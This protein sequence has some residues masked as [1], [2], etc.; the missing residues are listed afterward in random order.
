MTI[1]LDEPR[2]VHL[3]GIGG[4]GMSGI[5]RMLLQ[6]GHGVTGSD[7]Q[8]G[9]AVEGLRAMGAEIRIGHEADAVEGADLVVTSSAIDDD[10]VELEAAR[11][12]GITVLHRAE[13]LATLMRGD[14]AV[15]VAGTH[16]KTTTTSMIVVALQSAGMDPSFAIGG[17]LNEAGSNAH[18]GT[19]E[20]FVAEAD[21]SDRSFLS[22]R[23]DVAVVT[24]VELDHHEAFTS[25]EDTYEAFRA[26]LGRRSDDGVAVIC[27]DDEG[28]AELVGRAAGRGRVVTYGED[29]SADVRLIVDRDRSTADDAHALQ[30][31]RVR[32]DGRDLITFELSVPGVHNLLNATAALAVC[33]LVDADL[34]AAAEGLGSFTGAQR[35]FQRLGSAAGVE[36]VDDYA[37]HPT[38]LRVTLGAARSVARERVVLVVQP[39]RFSRTE[40]L[41]PELGRAAVGADVVVVTD[42]YGAD[43]DPVPGITGE[44]V[45]DA[46]R[47]AG[48][49]VIWEPHL[50][51]VVE[52]L[53][54]LVE[55]G[56]LVLVTGA[57]D[58]NEVGP[59]LLTALRE[60]RT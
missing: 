47:D 4:A 51:G 22:Y 19:G 6:R 55:D 46:A 29:P 24:N 8:E 12:T 39:H 42:V 27:L 32:A 41:G 7:R 17:A 13:M 28:S 35:R 49:N 33:W 14:H 52:R 16:G 40:A 36:V 11:A 3:V 53:T 50:T 44:I 30:A 38:E 48:A 20:V 58:V 9:R 5:A 15:L 31:G 18:A 45:A 25:L 57:G 26:F 59:R 34:S 56:D 1:D 10:N 60:G 23:P 54:D 43:E 37:H 2:R 21:E